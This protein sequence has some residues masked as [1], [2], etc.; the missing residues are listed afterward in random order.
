MR[1]YPELSGTMLNAAA[2]GQPAGGRLGQSGRLFHPSHSDKISHSI[3]GTLDGCV[4]LIFH[5]IKMFQNATI[6][7]D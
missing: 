3:P 1:N 4:T 5:K 7:H 2:L 6:K